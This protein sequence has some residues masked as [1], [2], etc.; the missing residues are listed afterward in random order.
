MFLFLFTVAISAV[1]F[2][3]HAYPKV[4]GPLFSYIK[5]MHSLA[6]KFNDK[7]IAGYTL[8]PNVSLSKI[9]NDVFDNLLDE[10]INVSGLILNYTTPFL[11]NVT[12][13]SM[14]DHEGNLTFPEIKLQDSLDAALNSNLGGK[15]SD[16]MIGVVLGGVAYAIFGIVVALAL[17]VFYIFDSFLCCCCCKAQESSKASI[18][19]CFFFHIGT[20]LM[21]ISLI[22]T[23]LI[24]PAVNDVSQKALNAKNTYCHLNDDLYNGTSKAIDAFRNASDPFVQVITSLGQG[25][26]QSF[27]DLIGA[28]QRDAE[29]VSTLVKSDY[30]EEDIFA[31]FINNASAPIAMQIKKINDLLEENGQSNEKIDL[32]QNIKDVRDQIQ[33][34]LDNIDEMVSPLKESMD[35]LYD[36]T[37]NYSDTIKDALDLEAKFADQLNS[38]QDNANCSALADTNPSMNANLDKIQKY[39]KKI[40]QYSIIFIA[41]IAIIII[42]TAVIYSGLFTGHSKCSRCCAS[43]NMIFPILYTIIFLVLVVVTSLVGYVSYVLTDDFN[44]T[45]ANIGTGIT[46]LFTD[47]SIGFPDMK[48]SFLVKNYSLEFNVTG[49]SFT[50]PENWDPIKSI[51]DSFAYKNSEVT[52]KG[53]GTALD[54]NG[55]LRMEDLL[56]YIAAFPDNAN[57]QVFLNTQKIFTNEITPRI[58]DYIPENGTNIKDF[59]FE[60]EFY[61]ASTATITDPAKQQE[62]KED[63][64]TLKNMI[65]SPDGPYNKTY[66]VFRS[67]ILSTFANAY[68]VDFGVKDGKYEQYVQ[69]R[70]YDALR[71]FQNGVTS[72][73]SNLKTV[74]DQISAY[75]LAGPTLYVV[76]V[77]GRDLGTLGNEIPIALICATIGFF[78]Y[79]LFIWIR[80]R[81]MYTMQEFRDKNNEKYGLGV[82]KDEYSSATSDFSDSVFYMGNRK[83]NED[84]DNNEGGEKKE[85]FGDEQPENLS[86]FWLH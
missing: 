34:A 77:A 80:R 69:I 44:Q 33:S 12:T 26:Q 68:T 42:F 67:R 58:S 64:N 78:F 16:A 27:E 85:G 46:G 25:F 17:L 13:D 11:T 70:L 2:Y 47:R 53:L 32:T 71:S 61:K 40:N 55:I 37:K 5:T 29:A 50:F 9:V 62:L 8:K 43:T 14:G 35:N 31:Q 20:V 59:N 45:T 22:F 23:F 72:L 66:V 86:T 65:Y 38:F 15:D 63:L 7:K 39:Q 75:S 56:A 4:T 6:T 79:A 82:A 3:P 60:D 51:I 57:H 52:S 24:L 74:F 21:V 81:G 36:F 19:T 73:F 83:T 54:I 10:P 28:V 84:G 48:I 76:E 18:L 49:Y 1:D 30:Y 41:V